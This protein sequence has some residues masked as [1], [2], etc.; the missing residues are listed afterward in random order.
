M[1][2]VTIGNNLSRKA[3]IID[4]TTTLRTALEDNGVDYSIGM[5]SLD[6]STL[7]P[8]DL[9][10]T[11]ADFGITEKCYL[12][13]VVKADNAAIVKLV[14]GACVIESGE[15]LEHI[16]LLKKYR[17]DA[18]KLYSEGDKKEEIFAVGFT[19][20]A[21]SISSFGVSF[22]STTNADGKAIVTMMIPEGEA[23]A[24]KW[25][26]DYIGTSIIRLNKLEG[27]LKDAIAEVDAEKTLVANSIKVV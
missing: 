23:D 21:G 9:D 3:V 6:G 25:A 4:E 5:N 22:G 1:I 2:R 20:G 24:K 13:N 15:T 26:E 17:P 14:G 8:G 19:N 7:G 27:S 18:L 10:K 12:L 11:F 16:K